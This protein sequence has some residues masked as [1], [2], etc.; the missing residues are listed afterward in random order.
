MQSGVKKVYLLDYGW[1]AGEMGWF[2]PNP[3]VYPER[4]EAKV[5]E[6]VEIPVSGAL[7]EHDNGLLVVDTGG[8]PR[9]KRCGE[10][11]CGPCSP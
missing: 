6:W 10:K 2:M 4:N 7:I 9:R 8:H 1:L 5:T 3:G 11:D